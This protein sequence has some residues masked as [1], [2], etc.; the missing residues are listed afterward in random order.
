MRLSFSLANW[1]T[2]AVSSEEMLR[3]TLAWGEACWND[4]EAAT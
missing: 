2:A 1:T 3:A 4:A